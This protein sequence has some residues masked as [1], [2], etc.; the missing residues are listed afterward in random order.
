M[1]AYKPGNNVDREH[2]QERVREVEAEEKEEGKD[3]KI[4]IARTRRA[5][6]G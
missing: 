1:E 6:G 3:Q 5:R 2:E 4:E